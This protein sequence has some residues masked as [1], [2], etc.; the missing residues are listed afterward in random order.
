MNND[1]EILFYDTTDILNAVE[2]LNMSD[3]NNIGEMIIHSSN[4]IIIDPDDN[5]NIPNYIT[6]GNNLVDYIIIKNLKKGK[7]NIIRLSFNRENDV[8]VLYY[9]LQPKHYNLVTHNEIPAI[10]ALSNN[11]GFYCFNIKNP[12]DYQHC[13]I[14][15]E[16]TTNSS[17]ITINIHNEIVPELSNYASVILSKYKNEIFRIIFIS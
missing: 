12:P 6:N 4:G 9:Y 2:Q 14:Q 1:E 17:G 5:L 10:N 7:W 3:Y 13:S 16:Y 15:K 8:Y 11:I